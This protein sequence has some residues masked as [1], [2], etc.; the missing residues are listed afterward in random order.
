MNIYFS[1]V[2]ALVMENVLY[3]RD[4]ETTGSDIGANEDSA[5]GTSL[6]ALD[7]AN[8]GLKSIKRL[9]TSFLLHLG[10]KAVVLDLE[11]T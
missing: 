10:M 11:E 1:V 7:S 5:F 8:T 4:I 6:S 9:Q 2:W 3:V